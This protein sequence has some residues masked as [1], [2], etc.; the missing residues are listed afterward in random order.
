M[1]DVQNGKSRVALH[2]QDIPERSVIDAITLRKN[3]FYDFPIVFAQSGLL[4][5]GCQREVGDLQKV[6]KLFCLLNGIYRDYFTKYH[7]HSH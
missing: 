3:G 4:S 5:N 7:K 2:S 1:A 6:E